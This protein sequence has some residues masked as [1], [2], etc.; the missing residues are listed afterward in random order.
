MKVQLTWLED[1]KNRKFVTKDRKLSF[2]YSKSIAR[3]VLLRTFG[4]QS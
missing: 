2:S 4:F 3:S 1:A